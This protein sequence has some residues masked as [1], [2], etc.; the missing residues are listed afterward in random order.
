MDKAPEGA[1]TGKTGYVNASLIET[2]LPKP[3]DDNV[4]FICG[5]PGMVN[6]RKKL[7]H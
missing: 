1:W 5:P 4:I 2:H 3:S 6:V 7:N